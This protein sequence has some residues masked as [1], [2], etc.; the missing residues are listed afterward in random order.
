MIHIPT[1]ACLISTCSYQ[2][3]Y[4]A[5]YN[6]VDLVDDSLN[7]VIVVVIQYRLGVFGI[8]VASYYNVIHLTLALGFLPGNEIKAQGALNAGLRE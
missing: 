3:G 7:S 5:E 6:G 2:F 8:S 1:Y 4:A